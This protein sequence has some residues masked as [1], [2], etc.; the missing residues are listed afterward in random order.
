MIVTNNMYNS[1]LKLVFV[2]IKKP[3]I[4]NLTLVLP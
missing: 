3:A 4:V 1:F 2:C